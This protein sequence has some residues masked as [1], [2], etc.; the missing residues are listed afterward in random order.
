LPLSHS[1]AVTGGL[2][3][4]LGLGFGLAVIVG[5]TLGIGI[6]RTPGLVAGQLPSASAVLAVWIVGGV[7]TLIGAVCFAEL[8]TMLPKEGG[9]YAYAKHAFGDTIG[10]AV[11]WTD[12]LSYCAVLGYVSIGFGE[13]VRVLLPATPVT[14]VAIVVL[15]GLVALQL[16]GVQVSSRFQQAATAVKFLAFLVLV[17]AAFALHG[18]S[19]APASEAPSASA[20]GLVFALQ[21]VVITYGGW[22]SALYF[23]EEDRDPEANIPRSMIGGVVAVIVVYLLVNLALLSLLP[24][25]DLARS[26]LPAADAAG[27]LA[28]PAGHLIITVLSLISLPPMLNAIIMIG[29]RI[30]F[31]MGRD[32]L[33][34]RK[35]ATVGAGGTPTTAMLVTT[36]AAVAGIASGTFQRLVA[37]TAFFLVLNYAI[38]C[39]ALMVLRRREPTRARPF[40]A[41][42]YPW[43]AGIVLAGAV[44]IVAGT[45]VGD[46]VNAGGALALLAAGL[47]GRAVIPNRGAAAPLS[48]GDRRI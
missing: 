25:G 41:W 11:G 47:V 42:G 38:S 31:A 29:T 8:G 19:I 23:S 10:F 27:I 15:V 39:V 40:R 20:A 24:L 3:R 9:Y 4:V 48:E 7:Y 43:S 30:L 46:P 44:A 13:F 32:G 12:W 33:V 16:G 37:V 36:A 5:S 1:A 45:L 35:T 17:V 14:L 2:R 26:T 22:Q 6:L 34:W 18:L 21:A 28:G